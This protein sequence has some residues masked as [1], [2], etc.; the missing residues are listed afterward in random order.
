MAHWQSLIG[1]AL[2]VQDNNDVLY[3]GI[4]KA[5]TPSDIMI[6]LIATKHPPGEGRSESWMYHKQKG[7]KKKYVRVVGAKLVGE[8]KQLE[9]KVNE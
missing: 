4:L 7:K 5:I 9:M 2:R 6:E 1:K 3:E 8:E